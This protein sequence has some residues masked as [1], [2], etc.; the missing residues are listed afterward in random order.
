[1]ERK[2]FQDFNSIGKRVKE[3]REEL[4]FNQTDFA[5]ELNVT[6]T[7]VSE[8]ERAES[9]P[10]IKFLV[11]LAFYKNITVDFILTGRSFPAMNNGFKKIEEPMTKEKEV[12]FYSGIA[13]KVAAQ[14]V[15]G[16]LDERYVTKKNR[17]A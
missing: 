7:V 4:R 6:Q 14:T 12:E 8:I 3:I 1:M 10:S 5:K 16:F 9:K 11:S 15:I 17:S 13:A 2:D